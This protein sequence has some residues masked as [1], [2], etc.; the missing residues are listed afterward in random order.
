MSVTNFVN[1]R[2]AAIA[3]IGAVFSAKKIYSGPHPGMFNEAEIR[4]LAQ[5]TPAILTSFMGY[6]DEDRVIH[7]VSWVLYRANNKDLLYDGALKIVSALVPMLRDIDTDFCIG[8]AQ[9][10]D[11]QCLYSGSLDQMNVTLWGVKWDWEIREPVL[12]EEDGGVPLDD[13]EIFEGYDAEH[14]IGDASVSDTVFLHA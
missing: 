2:D 1:M 13:L 14:H 4:R 9:K 10:I 8:G 6:S 3:K 5:R 11:A 12:D 7:M